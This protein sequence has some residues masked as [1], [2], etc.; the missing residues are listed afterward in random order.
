MAVT[1]RRLTLPRRSRLTLRATFLYL[2]EVMPFMFPFANRV[3]ER[4]RLWVLQR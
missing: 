3:P 4:D 2:L 1:P